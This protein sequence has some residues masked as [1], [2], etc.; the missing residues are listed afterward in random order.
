[1]KKVFAGKHVII[2]GHAMLMYNIRLKA[3]KLAI[4]R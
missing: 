4:N 3:P 2:L 1:M